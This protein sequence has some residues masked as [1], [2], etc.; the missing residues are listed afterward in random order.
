MLDNDF[1]CLQGYVVDSLGDDLWGCGVLVGSRPGSRAAEDE[2]A[3]HL[4]REP[5][6]TADARIP[7]VQLPVHSV[8]PVT[9]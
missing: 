8:H 1:K 6:C 7:H 9:E 2:A 5:R 3:R 4:L